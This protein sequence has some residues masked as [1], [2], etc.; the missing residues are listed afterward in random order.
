[1]RKLLSDFANDLS[2]YEFRTL[3]GK[4]IRKPVDLL[5]G[6]PPLFSTLM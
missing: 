2:I 4:D 3:A 1:M 6:E 5:Y